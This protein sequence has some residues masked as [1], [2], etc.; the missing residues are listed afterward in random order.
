MIYMDAVGHLVSDTNFDE[1]HSFAAGIGL[2]REWFQ[3]KRLPHYD[4]TTNRKRVQALYA[5]AKL[6]STRDII[7]KMKKQ[8]G[9]TKESTI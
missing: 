4:L 1:L 2:K 5:G 9:V 8:E 6:C 3:D 7:R